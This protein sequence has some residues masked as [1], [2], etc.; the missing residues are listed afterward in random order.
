MTQS[1]DGSPAA[2]ELARE[3]FGHVSDRD[4]DAMASM[5]HED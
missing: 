2:A 5:V 1:N 4:S 3:Y